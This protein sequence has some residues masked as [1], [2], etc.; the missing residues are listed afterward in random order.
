M[1]LSL[2]RE[3]GAGELDDA[4]A[5]SKRP[6]IVGHRSIT[7][8]FMKQTNEDSSTHAYAAFID[9]SRSSHP[10]FYCNGFVSSRNNVNLHGRRI[11]GRWFLDGQ[12]TA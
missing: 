11:S 8:L 9:W 2:N 6:Y 4:G 12:N 10:Q 3:F 7:L 1:N 5:F